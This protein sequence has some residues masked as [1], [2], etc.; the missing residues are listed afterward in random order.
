[1]AAETAPAVVTTAEPAAVV[2][3]AE[4][5]VV[6]VVPAA[7]PAVL[8]VVPAAVTR[9]EPEEAGVPDPTRYRDSVR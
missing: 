8:A 3:T 5:T 1:M 7:G 6:A 9:R 2:T 4:P